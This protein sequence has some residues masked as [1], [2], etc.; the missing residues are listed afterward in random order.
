MGIYGIVLNRATIY[1]C[2]FMKINSVLEYKDLK[3]LE[4]EKPNLFKTWIALSEETAKKQDLTLDQ[5]Y[6]RY[7]PHYPEYTKVVGATFGG[8]YYDQGKLKKN[9]KRFID[10]EEKIVLEQFFDVLYE[11]SSDAM[12]SSSRHFKTL[13]GFNI[14]YNDIPLLIKR[15]FVNRD[16]FKEKNEIPLILKSVLDLKPW[17]NDSIIDL[18]NLWNFKGRQI[19]SLD[20]ICDFLGIEKPYELLT[21]HDTSKKY[22][23]LIAEGNDEEALKMIAIQGTLHLNVIIQIF[24]ILR[25]F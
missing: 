21:P 10:V 13:S 24:N 25:S 2:F 4:L 19:Y 8:I 17:E 15:F 7:A 9:I 20:L 3:T 14:V 12:N 18:A 22:W 23:N 16:K 6:E 1:D 11:L 5:Y